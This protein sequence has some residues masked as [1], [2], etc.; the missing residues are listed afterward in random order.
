MY[1][2]NEQNAATNLAGMEAAAGFAQVQFAAFER[3]Y[4]LSFN[5]TKSSFGEGANYTRALLDAKD[6]RQCL[7]LSTEY[8]HP[9]IEKAFSYVRSYLEVGTHARDEMTRL[10]EGQ[11]IDITKKAAAFLTLLA[12]YSP[13]GSEVAV[14]AMKSALESAENTFGGMKAVVQESGGST[15]AKQAPS[16]ATARESKNK[17]A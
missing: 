17:A 9:A 1:M 2:S 3:L 11:A 6:V 10:L 16:T 12:K 14:S 5:A 7:D 13:G 15:E 4:A 8:G